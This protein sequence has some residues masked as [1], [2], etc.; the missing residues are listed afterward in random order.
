MRKLSILMTVVY[1]VTNYYLCILFSDNI[2][3]QVC[4]FVIITIPLLLCCNYYS[5]YISESN[6]V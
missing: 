3:Y 6:E 2:F 5:K 4:L 1:M